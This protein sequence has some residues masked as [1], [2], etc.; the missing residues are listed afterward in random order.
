[1]RCI[2]KP[3]CTRERINREEQKQKNLSK[4]EELKL[5]LEEARKLGYENIKDLE[6]ALHKLTALNEGILNSIQHISSIKN[7]VDDFPATL[8][9]KA[10][11]GDKKGESCTD[12]LMLLKWAHMKCTEL[13]QNISNL[14]SHVS[15]FSIK[16]LNRWNPAKTDAHALIQSSPG[17]REQSTHA[18]NQFINWQTNKHH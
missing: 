10:A 1:M 8:I 4:I 14:C 5:A 15:Q 12:P 3:N 18:L 2:Y 7:D 11:F 17:M 13:R 6:E 9:T 16:A